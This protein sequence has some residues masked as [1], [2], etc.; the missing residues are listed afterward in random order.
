MK[1]M[2]TTVTTTTK[3]ATRKKR[4]GRETTIGCDIVFTSNE[5]EVGVSEVKAAGYDKLLASRVEGRVFSRRLEGVMNS[6]D[7][8]DAE[9]RF[10]AVPQIMD[11]MN[12]SD[13][14]DPEIELKL[15]EL[16][17]EEAQQIA[18]ME[19]DNMMGGWGDDR[20]LDEEVEAA[21]QEI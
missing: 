9:W 7:L 19:A 17:E 4:R 3:R 16:E 10:N 18:E 21:M 5:T 14:I 15:R 1:G 8:R 20:D 6:Y 2:R 11:E 12:V 13:Y